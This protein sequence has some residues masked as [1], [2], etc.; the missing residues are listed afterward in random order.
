MYSRFFPALLCLAGLAFSSAAFGQIAGVDLA[1]SNNCLACHQVD[2]K[3]VGPAFTV[4]AQR[5]A[6]QEGADAYLA[7]AI[8]NGGRGRWGAV[9]M[10]AQPQVSPTDAKLLA[11]WI[12]SLADGKAAAN[13]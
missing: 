5:F 6:G 2:K 9:P 7:G 1:K 13:Q 3:R 4:I 8:R 11:A 10:P 12:L